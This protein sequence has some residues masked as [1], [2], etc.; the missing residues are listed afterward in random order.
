MNR[1]I[2]VNGI[3]HVRATPE[4]YL[5]LLQTNKQEANTMLNAFMNVMCKIW[6]H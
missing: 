5:N 6:F 1:N 4:N 3:W 2:Y